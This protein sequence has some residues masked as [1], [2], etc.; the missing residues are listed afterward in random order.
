MD[1]FARYRRMSGYNVLFPLGLDKNGLPIEMAAEKKFG[2][3]LNNTPREQFIGMCRKVLEEA[4]AVSV[5]SFQRLGISF[6]SWK[7]G[8]GVGEIY[9]TD[10]SDYRALTQGTFIDLWNKGLI[11]EDERLNNYCP[12]CKT[13]L[14]DSELERK[15]VSTFLN[16]VKFRIKETQEEVTIATTRPE[17][18]WTASM[19]IFNPGDKRFNHLN[20]KTAIVPIVRREVPIVEDE[21]ANPE[22]GSGI[23]FMSSS[24]GDQDAI[25]FLRKRNI[26]PEMAVGPDGLMLAIAGPLEGLPTKKARVR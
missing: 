14:A 20:G 17:L 11:Y 23:V 16:F 2:I 24:A 3:K 25:R 5:N 10:S 12:G 9:E 6:N 15:E 26:R 1:M 13:T 8:S 4:G 7:L 18:L 21:E 22:F 19:V